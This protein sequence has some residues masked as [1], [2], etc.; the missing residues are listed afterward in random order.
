MSPSPEQSANQSS[1]ASNDQWTVRRVLDWTIGHLHKHGSETPR[2]DAEILLAHARGCARIELYTHFDDVLSEAERGVMRDLVQRRATSEPVAYL[3]GYREFFGLDFRVTPDVLIPRPETE[4]LVLE[5][6]ALA[7][8]LSQ[9]RILDVGTGSG[10]MAV[11]AAVN[12]LHATV[13][14]IDRNEAAVSIARENADRHAVADRIRFLTGDLFAPLAEDEQF[15][16]IVSNP[17]YVAEEEWETLPADVRLHE[18][19]SALLAGPDGLA[20]IR[21][22]IAEA[23]AYLVAGGWML[24]EISPE[25]QDAVA[26][27]LQSQER[28]AEIAVVKDLSGQARVA[29]TRK[30]P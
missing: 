16:F 30:R 18:P 21:R 25:Q 4:T 17:P 11:A 20:V 6:L 23:P 14:A 15:D 13:A 29:K 22:L 27:L 10:C 5:L 2:L 8:P 9:P 7:K 26:R 12:C 19:K 28:F 24:L 3:V 1:A